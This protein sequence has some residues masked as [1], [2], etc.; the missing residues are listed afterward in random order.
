[1]GRLIYDH[2]GPAVDIDDRT[3]AHLKVVIVAKLRRQESFTLSWE[4][5]DE[6]GRTTIWIH[7]TIPVQFEFDS[8]EPEQLNRQWIQRLADSAARGGGI[9]LTGEH[10]DTE[11]PAAS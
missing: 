5:P 7:P 10:T 1:M 8:A 9:V 3:L 4:R 11:A 2:I 6:Y